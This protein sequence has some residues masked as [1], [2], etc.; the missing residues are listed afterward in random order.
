MPYS[1]TVVIDADA[2]PSSPRGASAITRVSRCGQPMPTPKPTAASATA[3]N[4]VSTLAPS[5]PGVGSSH[6]SASRP[7]VQTTGPARSMRSAPAPVRPDEVSEPMLQPPAIAA[8][9]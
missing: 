8:V 7:A 9:R 3:T 4:V 2:K 5:A 6:A 1:C